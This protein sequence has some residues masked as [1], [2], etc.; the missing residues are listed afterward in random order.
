MNILAVSENHILIWIKLWEQ[1]EQFLYSNTIL[2]KSLCGLEL[3]CLFLSNLVMHSTLKKIVNDKISISI[4]I[5][6]N[7]LWYIFTS[8]HSQMQKQS[9]LINFNIN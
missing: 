3:V 4:V 2:S 8:R 1:R 5:I 9:L 6:V 7:H